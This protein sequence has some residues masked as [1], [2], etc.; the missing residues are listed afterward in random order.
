MDKNERD[1]HFQGFAD[2]LASEIDE[3]LHLLDNPYF[4]SSGMRNEVVT[5]IAQ[6]AYDLACYV[7]D[8]TTDAILATDLY[9]FRPNPEKI[10]HD[11]PDLTEWPK[12]ASE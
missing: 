4:V 10:I 9:S 12:T 5:L 6:R 3:V 8:E 11:I 1:T 2:L 7:A